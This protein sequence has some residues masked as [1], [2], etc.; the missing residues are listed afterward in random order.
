MLY[1]SDIANCYLS[2]LYTLNSLKSTLKN[3]KKQTAKAK[4]KTKKS[5]KIS[6]TLI[7]ENWF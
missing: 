2:I 1:H 5:T 7:E 4:T 3:L 6:F